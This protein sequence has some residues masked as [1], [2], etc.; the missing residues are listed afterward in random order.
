MFGETGDHKNTKTLKHTVECDIMQQK[1]WGQKLPTVADTNVTISTD[2]KIQC[3]GAVKACKHTWRHGH[4]VI[5]CND[6]RCPNFQ[7]HV[8]LH[9]ANMEICH[10]CHHVASFGCT[11]KNSRGCIFRYCECCYRNIGTITGP[12]SLLL[13]PC[14]ERDPQHNDLRFFLVAK[15][16]NSVGFDTMVSYRYIKKHIESDTDLPLDICDIIESYIIILPAYSL[17]TRNKYIEILLWCLENMSFVI[18]FLRSGTH[19]ARITG[20]SSTSHYVDGMRIFCDY[21]DWYTNIE[22]NNTEIPIHEQEL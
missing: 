4:T 2:E 14:M 10:T 15:T 22:I 9:L 18:Q 6:H 1:R 5:P 13:S 11:K 21:V 8:P 7:N 17:E 20:Y 16:I 12:G 19:H 3:V